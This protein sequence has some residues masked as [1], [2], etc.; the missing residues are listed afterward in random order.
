MG[1]PACSIAANI[2]CREEQEDN[3]VFPISLM[4]WLYVLK[5][6]SAGYVSLQERWF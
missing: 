5:E 2:F 3:N 1:F 4:L 6:E